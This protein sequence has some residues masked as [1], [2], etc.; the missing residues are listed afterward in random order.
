MRNK[1]RIITVFLRVNFE[2]KR[3]RIIRDRIKP[4]G[5]IFVRNIYIKSM[6]IFYGRSSSKKSY[7]E[8]LNS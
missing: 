4:L 7:V 1:C 3:N 6:E 5:I 8:L 2:K